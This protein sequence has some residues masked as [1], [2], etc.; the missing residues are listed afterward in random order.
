MGTV[1]EV[2]EEGGSK[3]NNFI[4]FLPRGGSSS[5]TVWFGNLGVYGS[6]AAKLEGLHMGF[7]RQVRGMKAQR[8][9]DKS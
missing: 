1:R 4:K 8:L 3:P 5:A 9:G 6:N 2:A 7:L